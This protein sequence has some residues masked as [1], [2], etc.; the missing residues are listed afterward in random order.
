MVQAAAAA[1]AAPEVEQPTDQSL[2]HIIPVA[3]QAA[4]AANRE[5][6]GDS[7]DEVRTRDRSF[8]STV[9][10]EGAAAGAAG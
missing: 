10:G 1:G 7:D 3:L 4:E 9:G 6:A 8:D 2:Q 5:V